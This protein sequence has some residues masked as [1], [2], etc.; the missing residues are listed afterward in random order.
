MF[1]RNFL[2]CAFG[3]LWIKQG[4]QRPENP[5]SLGI[6]LCFA[7]FLETP[8]I[9]NISP[10]KWL[11]ETALSMFYCEEMALFFK[12]K[13]QIIHRRLGGYVPAPPLHIQRFV[14]V[15]RGIVVT[16]V[17]AMQIIK[18]AVDIMLEMSWK[19]LE[20][21]RSIFMATQIKRSAIIPPL[22]KFVIK[23]DRTKILIFIF[24]NQVG[25]W[26]HRPKRCYR[27]LPVILYC[28]MVLLFYFMLIFCISIFSLMVVA[29]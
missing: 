21:W 26:T 5:G 12:K 23:P 11:L 3:C 4:C 20:F 10:E 15:A 16:L 9:V 7:R 8:L 6:F 27:S 28:D 2:S 1:K 14:Y 17:F 25:C 19:L 13:S 29:K 24:S 22:L 18:C